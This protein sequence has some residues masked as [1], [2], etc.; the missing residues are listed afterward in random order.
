MDFARPLVNETLTSTRAIRS[1]REYRRCFRLLVE[2]WLPY[3]SSE[4]P[5][6]VPEERLIDI[7]RTQT[8]KPLD[9][10]NEAR[11]L[12]GANESFQIIAKQAKQPCIAVGQCS[13]G[14]LAIDLIKTLLENL[15]AQR[16]ALKILRT[17]SAVELKPGTLSETSVSDHNP[18][19]SPTLPLENFSGKFSP[20]L[21]SDFLNADLRIV[22]GELKP[23]HFLLYTGICDIVFPGLASESS[24]RS[25]LA[26]RPGFSAAHLRKERDEITDKVNN[27]YALGVVLDSGKEAAHVAFGNVREALSTLQVALNA[28]LTRDIPKLADIVVLSAGGTPDDESL[29]QAI[30]TFPIGIGAL[31]R[32]GALIIAAECG[33]GHGDTEF[34]DWTVERKQ[35]HHL[36]ARL[37]HNF[38]Y[39]GFKAA[40]LSRALD[41]HRIYLVSTIPDYYV[42]NVFGMRA[43]RTVNAAL[44]T[45]QRALGAESKISVIPDATRLIPKQQP[46]LAP[47]S[48]DVS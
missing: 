44:Q 37:R 29:L 4:I 13:N 26:N 47:T 8:P 38:N 17:Q 7:F 39:N 35:A 28:T 48:S 22:V 11:K 42:E 21:N 32:N 1:E 10:L 43:S 46:P 36:E 33:K 18:K 27:T 23:N 24:L 45:A 12:I 14:P 5:V 20:Q 30:E 31:K 34:Y 15:G 9:T 19:L 41:S 40:Y 6:R 25:H 3:G 2:V 16:P